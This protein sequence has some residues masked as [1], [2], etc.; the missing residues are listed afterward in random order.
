MNMHAT[1]HRA[2]LATSELERL[3]HHM[4]TVAEKATNEWTANFARSIVR[5]SRRRGWRPSAKQLPII[6]QLV[7]D[8]FVN[9]GNEEGDFEVIE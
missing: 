1:P 7:A 3:L 8:L 4:P 6:R 2:A 5:Q 9:D